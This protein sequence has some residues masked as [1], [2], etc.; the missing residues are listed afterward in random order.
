M[1]T[2]F[3]LFRIGI[4]DASLQVRG[5]LAM[6]LFRASARVPQATSP[7]GTLSR[8]DALDA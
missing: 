2:L 4:A 5:L 7:A 1:A 3:G 6:G 8:G